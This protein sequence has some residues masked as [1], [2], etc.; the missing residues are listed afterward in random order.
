MKITRA[1][2]ALFLGAGLLVAPHTPAHAAVICPENGGGPF[3]LTLNEAPTPAGTVGVAYNQVLTTGAGIALQV[4]GGTVAPGITATPTGAALDDILISGTPTTAGSFNATVEILHA[5]QTV[6]CTWTFVI[7]GAGGGGAGGGGGFVEPTLTVGDPVKGG[8]FAEGKTITCTSS[9]F[10]VTPSRI[11][12]YF[13]KNGVE[14]PDDTGTNVTSVDVPSAP[15]AAS[16]KL[17]DD[18]IDSTIGCTVYA[19]SGTSEKTSTTSWGLLVAEPKITRVLEIFEDV[20]RNDGTAIFDNPAVADQVADGFVGGKFSLTGRALA[21]FTFSLVKSTGRVPTQTATASERAVTVVSRTSI[22]A[23]LQLPEVTSLGAY[24]LI[25][26][27]ATKTINFPVNI[28]KPIVTIAN[29]KA[30]IAKNKFFLEGDKVYGNTYTTT[31]DVLPSSTTITNAFKKEFPKGFKVSFI[32]NSEFLTDATST[33]LKKLAKLNLVEVIIT[34]YGF[35]G[36]TIKVNNDLATARASAISKALTN[37]GLKNAKII[38]QIEQFDLKY[39]RQ[40]VMSI[41]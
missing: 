6:T 38:I 13:T 28:P 31:N 3:T 15:G 23:T 19:K 21:S 14:I 16:L 41:R 9:T 18:L 27:T 24:Y 10:S 36:G 26:R 39:S 32:K 22:N 2:V 29:A 11:R 12:I 40:A 7:N 5:T 37:A 30:L 33:N 34:G 35:K 17:T 4:T 20:L 8:E 1:L 25:A